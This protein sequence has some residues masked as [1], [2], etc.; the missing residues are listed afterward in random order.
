MH[1]N[2]T[3]QVSGHFSSAAPE[4]AKSAFGSDGPTEGRRTYHLAAAKKLPTRKART[5][6]RPHVG[7]I[8]VQPG[9]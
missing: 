8:T 3:A 4:N 2:A 7:A 1:L 6:H 5:G 9:Q